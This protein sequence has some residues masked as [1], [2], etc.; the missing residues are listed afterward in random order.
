VGPFDFQRVSAER[1][2]VHGRLAPVLHHHRYSPQIELLDKP[3]DNLG[4][5]GRG[6]PVSRW[7]HRQPETR[8]IE[9]DTAKVAS[10]PLDDLAV[11][12]RP[13]R[14]AMQ[15][16]QCRAATLIDIM[17]HGLSNLQV[18]TLE[19]VQLFRQPSRTVLIR[20]SGPAVL[21]DPPLG[22]PSGFDIPATEQLIAACHQLPGHQSGTD[23][24]HGNIE[25]K[26]HPGQ[27]VSGV[28]RVMTYP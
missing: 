23:P 3:V 1:D 16:Q 15:Q 7:W 13:G 9:R 21:I 27:V 20:H 24:Q 14:V 28:G 10:E 8:V 25:V 6:K 11:K 17:H 5:F 12:K 18:A 22:R 4:M 19:R 2:A 26:D